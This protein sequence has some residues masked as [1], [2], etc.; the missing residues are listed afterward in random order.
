M[1]KTGRIMAVKIPAEQGVPVGRPLPSR[2]A[3]NIRGVEKQ[4]DRVLNEP[5][6]DCRA[7]RRY[8]G[9]TKL[10]RDFA[11]GPGVRRGKSADPARVA[12]DLYT[13]VEEMMK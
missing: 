5:G 10:P 8:R 11:A 9:C 2:I 12:G 6:G 4:G 13:K 1:T 3:A 7:R